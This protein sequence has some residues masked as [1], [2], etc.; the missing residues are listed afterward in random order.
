MVPPLDEAAERLASISVPPM[1]LRVLPIL[2]VLP[3]KCHI[4]ATFVL[5]GGGLWGIVAR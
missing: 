5:K 4:L 3:P 1:V 2:R